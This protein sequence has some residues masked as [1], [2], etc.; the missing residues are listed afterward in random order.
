[1]S[2][3]TIFRGIIVLVSI[4]ILLISVLVIHVAMVTKS[5]NDDKRL[6]QLARIDFKEQLDSVAQQNL[7]NKVLSIPGIDA[8]YYNADDHILVYSYNPEILHSDLV[9]YQLVE[10]KKYNAERFVVANNNSNNSK[11]CPVIDKSSFSY[12][13]ANAVQEIIK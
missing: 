4:S 2:R 1:M 5:K 10:E 9:Y 8:A 13:F 3:K 12:Q 6:R 7:K 11:G